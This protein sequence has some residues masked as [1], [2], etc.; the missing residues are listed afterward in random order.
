MQD[1]SK[2]RVI[3][4]MKI[5][6]DC[7]GLKNKTFSLFVLIALL[8][9][10]SSMNSSF[11]CPMKAGVRCESLDQVNQAVDRGEIRDVDQDKLEAAPLHTRTLSFDS[12]P[13]TTK[14]S[15]GEP[16]RFSESVQRIWIAP[17]EDTAGN[18]HQSSEVFTITQGGHWIGDPVKA[19]DSDE[20]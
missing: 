15:H 6:E 4:E 10:C 19:I 17:F 11:D 14:L 2:I 8:S 5:T 3:D 16:L 1:I 9:G 7:L 20:D 13:S 18:Y 12:Y